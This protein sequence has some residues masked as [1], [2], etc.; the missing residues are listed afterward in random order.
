[1]FLAPRGLTVRLI[2]ALTI[3]VAIIAIVFGQINVHIQ[4]QNLLDEIIIGANQLSGSITSATWHTMLADQ[5]DATYRIMETIAVD[6]AITNLR[7]FNKEGR[8]TFSTDPDA[9]SQVDKTAEACDMCHAAEQPLVRVDTPS[10]ARTF[11]DASNRHL[12]GMVKPIYN[13]PSCSNATCHVHPVDQTVLGVVDITMDLSRIDQEVAN[14]RTRAILMTVIQIVLIGVLIA[15]FTR[16][17]VANPIRRLIIGTKAISTMDLE[18]PINVNSKDELGELATSFDI[19]RIRL[20]EA[21]NSLNELTHDLENKV[22]ERTEQLS[23]AQ[24]K[25]S[26]YDKLTSLGQLAASVAHEINNPISGCLNLS[27]LMQ[28]ILKDDGIPANRIA[29]F[30]KYLAAISTETTRV[31]RIVSDLLSFSRRSTPQRADADLN[32]IVG[33]TITLISHKLELADINLHL[34]LDSNLPQIQ[35]DRS[36]IQQVLINLVMNAAEAIR[37]TGEI[38]IRTRRN[39]DKDGIVLEV[40]DTGPGIAPEI[41][42][43]LFDPFFTTKE[44]GKGVGLGLA[45]VYGIID[46][47]G[48]SIDAQNQVNGGAAFTVRLPL[49]AKIES[50]ATTDRN[51]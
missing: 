15:L 44:E 13:E 29:D 38:T 2:L 7:I 11:Y 47:H 23:S 39:V 35:C 36:Q 10:R 34:W 9:P 17:F 4:E 14:I 49:K 12:L 3:L 1:M 42:G 48:G 46:A 8:V 27:M 19:M 28:R 22:A 51:A 37:K 41:V 32:Q 24:R 21:L 26:R 6:Q 18:Q 50:I 20:K 16:R 33:H 40:T 5:P 45:V 30:R 25:L 31:G 43:K